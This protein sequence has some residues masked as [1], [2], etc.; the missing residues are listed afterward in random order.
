MGW[1]LL[2]I[3]WAV[4]MGLL[5][6]SVLNWAMDLTRLAMPEADN[7]LV[8]GWVTVPAFRGAWEGVVAG[9]VVARSAISVAES[10][11]PL[12]R[13]IRSMAGPL[14]DT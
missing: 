14:S 7:S 8:V 6:V 3:S 1:E 11:S 5:P 9:C 13:R 2:R 10:V 12:E 4:V